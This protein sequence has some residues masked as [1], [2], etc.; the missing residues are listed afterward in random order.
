NTGAA[1][2]SFVNNGNSFGGLATLGTNDGFGLNLETSGMDRIQIANSGEV[3]ITDL[4]GTAGVVHND[5]AGLL[6]S[7]LIVN[8]DVDAAAAIV[9]TKL[10]T[11]STAGKVLNSATTATAL[12]TPSAIVARD[13]SGNFAAGIGTFETAIA[14]EDSGVGTN[15]ITLQSP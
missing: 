14:L 2:G 10:D 11:I 1:A 15:T 9:D 5:A 8:A 7:S 4:A 12:N 6:T 13:G 3:T